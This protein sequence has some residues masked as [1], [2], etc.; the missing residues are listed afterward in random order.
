MAMGNNSFFE[1][2]EFHMSKLLQRQYS[3]L[4]KHAT[5]QNHKERS[6][7]IMSHLHFRDAMSPVTAYSKHRSQLFNFLIEQ[8][9]E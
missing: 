7:H 3:T 1:N 5:V 6:L 4:L 9:K 8:P 2:K